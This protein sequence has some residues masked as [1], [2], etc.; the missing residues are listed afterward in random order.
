M[1]DLSHLAETPGRVEFFGPTSRE[2]EE[3]KSW[4][5][6]RGFSMLSIYA[7]GAGGG[8]GGGRGNTA[9]AGKGGGGGGG[10]GAISRLTIP[11][12]LLP[13]ML[14]Y[15]MGTGGYGGGGGSSANGTVG[16]TSPSYTIVSVRPESATQYRLVT[17]IYG[18][19]GIGGSTTSAAGGAAASISTIA[20]NPLAT[21]GSF[22]SIAGVIGT[23]AG[24][25]AG[26]NAGASHTQT[27]GSQILPGC[28]GGGSSSGTASGGGITALA[29]TPFIA[30][31][32]GSAG[33]YGSSGFRF[34]LCPKFYGGTGGGSSNTTTGG[35]GGNGCA[36]GT[37]GGG[38]GGGVTVGGRGGDGGPG[39]IV[40]HCW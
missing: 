21:L 30:S 10:S 16:G 31:P 17:A 23:A 4:Y 25:G 33:A 5:K 39:L 35:A 26:N 7:V 12:W 19:G 28:G 36:P 29:S 6:P 13:D 24:S 22:I 14:W 11:L 37:G 27:T 8:G 40:F 2:S 1:I 32:G 38:G 34:G 3:W 20:D 15:R 18:S 9:G